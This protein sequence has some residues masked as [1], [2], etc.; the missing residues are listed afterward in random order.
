M[1]EQFCFT[2]DKLNDDIKYDFCNAREQHKL[3]LTDFSMHSHKCFFN[4]PFFKYNKKIYLLKLHK[5]L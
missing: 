3:E 1:Y 4:I 2:L 5:Y